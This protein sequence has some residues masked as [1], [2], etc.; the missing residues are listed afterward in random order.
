MQLANIRIANDDEGEL[1][2]LTVDE[3]KAIDAQMRE[4]GSM[5][6]SELK[7]AV[8]TLTKCTRD[9]LETML[10]HPDAKDA[11]LLDPVRKLVSS[12]KLKTLWPLLPEKLQRRA[13]NVWQRGKPITPLG[14]RDRLESGGQSTAQFDAEVDRV[15]DSANT[16]KKHKDKPL[17][18]EEFLAE[19]LVVRRFDGRAAYSRPILRQA[20]AEVMVGKHPK[21]EGGCL[22]RSEEIRDAQ[23]QRKID[24]QT[25]NHLVRHRLLI[26]ERLQRDIIKEYASSDAGRVGR[27]TIE[28]NRDLSEM[29]G[30]TAKE[31]AQGLGL[32]LANFKSVA[33]KL[34]E[35]FE[36]KNIHVAPGL[37][38]KARIAEDLGWTCPYT[39]QRYDA[40]QL[41]NRGVD[42][43]HII[44]RTQRTSD[45]L[46]SLVI[47]FSAVNKWKGK[48]TALKFVKDEQGK[49]VPDMPNLSIVTLAQYKNFVEGLET[50]KGHDDDKRRKRNRQRLLL[51][52]DYEEAEFT[53][54]DLTQ[55]SQLVRLGAQ[56]LQKAYAGLA[57]QPPIISTP[58][59]VTANV[60]NGWQLLGCLSAANPNVLDEGGAPKIKTDIR[61]ITH[62]HH[63]LDACVLA[64]AS[65]YIP[66]DG[67]IWE[68]I[69]KRRL[70]DAEQL[71][72]QQATKGIFKL[73]VERRFGIS[74]LPN[75][76]KKQLRQRLAERR[77]VQHVPSEMSGLPSQLN[78]WRV[79]RIEGSR[80]FLVQRMRQPDN[81]RPLN[82][83]DVELTK[84]VGVRPEQGAGKLKK[85]KGALILE[86][87]Y[88]AVLEPL[89]TIIPFHKVWKRLQEF[90]RANGGKMPRI[91]RSG[92]R[93]T[94]PRGRYAGTWRVF[95]VKATLTV[96]LGAPDKVQLENKGLGTKREVQIKTLIRDGVEI[97]DKCLT[98]VRE[99]PSTS[100]A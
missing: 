20:F 54:R 32:R 56:V 84:T 94:V 55:T 89:P 27:V 69:T 13:S 40:F 77:V 99:C 29:S 70:S 81:S 16:K 50:F 30:K 2:S 11:L 61:A 91:L 23:L 98:G 18:R 25:N 74:E 34:E 82:R 67:T 39:G 42:K 85:L 3:R 21:E 92:Q 60:R 22:F 48:R 4:R 9:N 63:A 90:K 64:L 86:K 5:T 96:D 45:S 35:A 12:D 71:Q 57:A 28:V 73:S 80:A 1:R 72:L 52:G 6:E 7:K 62:L 43:D 17:T 51:I 49:P 31:K 15:I 100:S 47:T 59:S 53:P 76:L 14:L 38:R 46:D 10:M 78:T 24:D 44:P 79:E 37:I 75:D 33:K 93:I 87:N 68:L 88:G 65:H 58:G 26:L 41:F 95:S 83:K 19:P 97:A 8:R 66:R 36:G